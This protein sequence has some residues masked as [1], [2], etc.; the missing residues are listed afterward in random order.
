MRLREQTVARRHAAGCPGRACRLLGVSNSG[1]Y[2]WLGRPASAYARE[3]AELL[4]A[5]KHSDE[6]SD[7]T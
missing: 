3:N 5:I 4:K 6:A 2:D 1:F 7:G